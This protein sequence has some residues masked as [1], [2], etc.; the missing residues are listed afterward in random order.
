MIKFSKYNGLGNDF[1][2]TDEKVS[3]D[4]VKKL[5]DRHFGI[6]ADGLII[7]ETKNGLPFMRFF[8]ADGSIAKMC[9]NGIRCFA[10]YLDLNGDDYSKIDTLAGIKQVEKI[11]DKY[12]VCLGEAKINFLDKEIELKGKTIKLNFVDTGTDHCCI[13][14]NDIDFEFLEKYG[15]LIE[16]NYS[17]FPNG[18][19]VNLVHIVSEN[20][21]NVYTWER[22]V[23]ITLACGTGAGAS[24]Y[25]ANLQGKVNKDC[26]VNLLGGAVNINVVNGNIYMTGTATKVFDGYTY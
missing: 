15:K 14:D 24:V 18:T 9:G 7:N 17:I 13:I 20:E 6:G 8:N 5:C 16:K 10:K 26:R 4:D 12:K 25:V 3:Q 2:I 23:G 19:N 1:I 21:I 11:E 22:G